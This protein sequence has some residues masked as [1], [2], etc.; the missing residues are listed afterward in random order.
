MGNRC[1]LSPTEYAKLRAKLDREFSN[2][3]HLNI[4][5]DWRDSLWLESVRRNYEDTKQALAARRDRRYA[6]HQV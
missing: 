6:L 2:A 5:G 3:R 1:K 4:Y